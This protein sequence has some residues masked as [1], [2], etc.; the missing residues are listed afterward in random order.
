MVMEEGRQCLA[1]WGEVH[2]LLGACV[3]KSGDAWG[4]W[5][6]HYWI[7]FKDHPLKTLS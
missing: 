2:I 5:E 4:G 6:G 7:V 3:I 1:T